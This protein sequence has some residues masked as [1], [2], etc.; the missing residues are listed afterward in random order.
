MANTLR[1]W[2]NAWREG[3]PW[4]P[5]LLVALL[6]YGSVQE[7][8]WKIP[9][10]REAYTVLVPLAAIGALCACSLNRAVSGTPLTPVRAAR[11]GY[12]AM[13]GQAQPIPDRPLKGSDT[14]NPCVWYHFSYKSDKHFTSQ[15]SRRPFRLVDETGEVLVMPADAEVRYGGEGA[16]RRIEPGDTLYVLGELRPSIE[17]PLTFVEPD[18]KFG[19]VRIRL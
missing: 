12:V 5:L 13:R 7:L 19:Q 10:W 3:L 1:S 6:L 14:G 8:D 9:L 2:W 17:T 4:L 15:E 11:P 16:E 18:G